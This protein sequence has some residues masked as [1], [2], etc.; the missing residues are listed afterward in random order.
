MALI[1]KGSIRD[2]A[3]LVALIAVAAWVAP[4]LHLYS[5]DL[6]PSKET[7]LADFTEVVA[8]GVVAQSPTYGAPF[9]DENG[10]AVVSGG[11]IVF[12]Q[13]AAPN[14]IAHGCYLTNTASNV[15]LWSGRFDAPFNFT[16]AS[17]LPL[18]FKMSIDN[19]LIDVADLP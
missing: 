10:I 13:N 6:T 18:T 2:L 19:G 5:D 4:K 3:D 9:V 1:V 16:G 7:L 17:V 15:L 11:E 12:T 14:D 8:G